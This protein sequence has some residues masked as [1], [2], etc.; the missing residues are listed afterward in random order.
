MHRAPAARKQRH[1]SPG[2][3]SVPAWPV[4]IRARALCAPGAQGPD[5]P[6]LGAGPHSTVGE[7][8]FALSH[9]LGQQAGQRREV[10]P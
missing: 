10:D 2:A 4:P 6:T 9:L 1:S 3:A 8:S 5:L 7:G